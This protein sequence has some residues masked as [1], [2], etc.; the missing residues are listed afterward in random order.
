MIALVDNCVLSRG[1]ETYLVI[2]TTFARYA[3]PLT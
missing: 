3:D 2:T 1:E